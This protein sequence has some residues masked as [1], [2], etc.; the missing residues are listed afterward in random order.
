MSG[1]FFP[2][3]ISKKFQTT[4]HTLWMHCLAIVFDLL[5]ASKLIVSHEPHRKKTGVLLMRKQRRRS[6]SQ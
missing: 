3:L 5:E 2:H 4:T 1:I 6:A